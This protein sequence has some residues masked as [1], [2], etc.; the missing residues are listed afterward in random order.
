MTLGTIL[1]AA[2]RVLRRNPRPTFGLALL[3]EGITIVLGV[4]VVALVFVFAFSRVSNAT[5]TSAAETIVNGSLGLILLAYLVPITLGVFGLAITQGVFSLEVARGTL[6]EKLTLGGLWRRSR[7]RMGALIGW[8]WAIVGVAIV[9]YVIVVVLLTIVIVV[10]GAVGTVIG[11]LLGILLFLG[12]IVLVVWLAP[13]LSM[14]PAVLM[15]ERLTLGKAIRRSW[16]L[17]SGYFWRTLGIELLV[18]VIINTAT[19]VVTAPLEIVVIAITG[20]FNQ[21]GDQATAIAVGVVVGAIGVIL[22]V[23]LGAVASVVQSSTTALLY[24]DLRI[25]KEA[26]DLDLIRFVEARQGGDASVLDPYLVPVV[27]DAAP[28]PPP[29]A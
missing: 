23:V 5:S 26:L 6:G 3:I 8:F 29:V 14:V 18:L 28:P 22:T 15:I 19:S 24:I 7:G 2:F 12:A 13:K 1:G 27:A 21:T 25:R 16:R 20:V 4:G 17:T 10:G 9:A 11:I